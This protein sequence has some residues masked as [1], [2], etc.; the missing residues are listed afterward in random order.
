[1]SPADATPE[2]APLSE[3][4]GNLKSAEFEGLEKLNGDMQKFSGKLQELH[5][6]IDKHARE[7]ILTERQRDQ[8]LADI[9]ELTSHMEKALETK[10][11]LNAEEVSAFLK[12]SKWATA[13]RRLDQIRS[14]L[15][16]D[17]LVQ[18]RAHTL[19]TLELTYGKNSPVMQRIRDSV[20]LHNVAEWKAREKAGDDEKHLKDIREK[21]TC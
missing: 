5:A 18:R 20:A 2:S 1:M 4:I 19:H 6:F 12:E 15:A 17:A 13:F 7:G 8:W 3:R 21:S 16:G 11:A 14:S 10:K 9:Q